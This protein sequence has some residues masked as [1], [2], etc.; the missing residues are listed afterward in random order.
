MRF[1]TRLAGLALATACLLPLAACSDNGGAADGTGRLS[2]VL[3]DAPG[4]LAKAVV[5]VDRINLIGEDG[6][7]T[8][9]E[10]DFT[11]DLLTLKN[12]TAE[13]LRA[14]VIPA[15]TYSELRFVISGG[16]VETVDG[17]VYASSEDYPGLLEIPAS[18]P[19]TGRLQMPSFAQSGLKVKLPEDRLV[20][21]DG[22]ARVLL[23]DFDVS[24]SFGHQAGNSG[25]WVMHPVVRA[26]DFVLAAEVM[27]TAALADGVALPEGV[28]LGSFEAVLARDNG[29][30]TTSEESLP[31]VNVNGAWTAQFS[32]LFAGTYSL[33][34]RYAGEGTAPTL[35]TDPVLPVDITVE[36]G[37]SA[38]QAVTI[39]AVAGS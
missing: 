18:G 6:V 1:P 13:L 29:D 10:D 35:T 26:T 33:T 30:G 9:R 20:I 24:Q 3:T 39:T 38:S 15:G 12:A 19:V 25:K 17:E 11:T 36:E 23:V 5:T 16:Y 22:A 21:G 27:V 2:L 37:G 4:E 8:V 28:T 7:V 14:E 32:W 31:L 34:L